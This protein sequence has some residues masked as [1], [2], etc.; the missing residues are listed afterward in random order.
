M[1][2]AERDRAFCDAVREALVLAGET[3]CRSARTRSTGRL[4]YL[5]V[6]GFRLYE[7]AIRPDR[8][9][10]HCHDCRY[11]AVGHRSNRRRDMRL[12]RAA[13]HAAGFLTIIGADSVYP[14]CV[15]VWVWT[16]ER[17]AH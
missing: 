11:V 4:R 15:R 3:E 9:P 1:T 2:A 14:T 16:D 13:L 10:E 6:D 17:L 12:Y 7:S 5:P 8:V